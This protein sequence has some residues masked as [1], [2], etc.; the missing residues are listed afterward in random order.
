VTEMCLPKRGR[1]TWVSAAQNCDISRPRYPSDLLLTSQFGAY[2]DSSE[3]L[4]AKF[5][6]RVLCEVG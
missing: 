3:G 4:K 1:S 2:F 5:V 6:V